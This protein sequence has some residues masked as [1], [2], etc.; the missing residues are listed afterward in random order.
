MNTILDIL[1]LLADRAADMP[2][3]TFLALKRT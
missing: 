2:I 3:R 1:A